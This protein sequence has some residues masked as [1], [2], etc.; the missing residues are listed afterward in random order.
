MNEWDY[1]GSWVTPDLKVPIVKDAKPEEVTLAHF[2]EVMANEVGWDFVA[3]LPSEKEG[4]QVMFKRL[5]SVDR[6][7]FLNA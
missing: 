7:I 4:F 5:M 3:L 2:I 6:K 1:M